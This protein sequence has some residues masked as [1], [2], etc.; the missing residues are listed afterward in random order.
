MNDDIVSEAPRRTG[1]IRI[2]GPEGFEGMRKAGQ[3][4]AACLDMLTEHVQPGVPTEKLD[5]L[6][7]EFVKDNGAIPATVGYRGYKHASCIST[8][9]ELLWGCK[10]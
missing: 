4:A 1:E 10:A 6:A 5:K 8:N 7:F 2:H 3:L 9:H